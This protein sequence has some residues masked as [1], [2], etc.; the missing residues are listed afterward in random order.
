MSVFQ[1]SGTPLQATIAQRAIDLCDFPFDRLVDGIKA[2][3]GGRTYVPVEWRDLS[4][5]NGTSYW[6]LVSRKS[7][8]T[9]TTRKAQRIPSSGS[10]TVASGCWAWRTTRPH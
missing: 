6:L 1:L 4:R 2:S 7:T 9:F 8:T 10:S 5:Y 3:T